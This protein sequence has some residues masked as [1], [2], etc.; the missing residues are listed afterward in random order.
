[1]RKTAISAMISSLSKVNPKDTRSEYL[2][3]AE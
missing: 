1:M 2:R 3:L